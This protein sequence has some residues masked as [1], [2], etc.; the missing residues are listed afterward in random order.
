MPI[1]DSIDEL[2]DD[3]DPLDVFFVKT[4]DVYALVSASDLSLDEIKTVLNSMH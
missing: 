3:L 4:G 1:Y 2:P